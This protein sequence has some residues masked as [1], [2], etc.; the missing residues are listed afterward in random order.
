MVVKGRA[1][2]HQLAR[3]RVKRISSRSVVKHLAISIGIPMSEA[4]LVAVANIM[5]SS[6]WAVASTELVIGRISLSWGMH[7]KVIPIVIQAIPMAVMSI[8][9]MAIDIRSMPQVV[10]RLGHQ[11]ARS[12][13]KRIPSR[14]IVEHLTISIGIPM[15][16]AILVAVANIMASS[17]WAVAST[18]LVIVGRISLS[19]GMHI[20]VRTV[21]AMSIGAMAIDVRSMPQVVVRLGHQLARSRVKR[22]SSRSVVQHLTIPIGIP[23]SEAI[24]VAVANIMASSNRAVASTELVIA[25]DNRSSISQPGAMQIQTSSMGSIAINLGSLVNL[26]SQH[27]RHMPLVE[28]IGVVV[29]EVALY[30]KVP[31]I[32]L[33]SVQSRSMARCSIGM[34]I[35]VRRLGSML[36]MHDRP[37]LLL[38][39]WNQN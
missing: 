22:V 14:S 13:V 12:R 26:G 25:M 27:G 11:L 29:V 37:I 35:P 5:A 3:S 7:I 21:A 33:R 39:S 2:G 31:T 38:D 20:K 1:L 15:S 24:L 6:H 16:E 34:I 19:W 8:G 28:N 4:I 18:E 17:H 36:S 23:V 30:I 10:V 9:A 32:G